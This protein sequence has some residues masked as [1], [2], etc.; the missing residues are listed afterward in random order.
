MHFCSKY[1]CILKQMLTCLKCFSNWAAVSSMERDSCLYLFKIFSIEMVEFDEH[2]LFPCVIYR[3]YDKN[4]WN[5]DESF[6][7]YV[8]FIY[9]YLF[10]YTSKCFP[11]LQRIKELKRQRLWKDNWWRMTAAAFII[12]NIFVVV[13]QA[14][15]HNNA[16]SNAQST[17]IFFMTVINL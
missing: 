9:T 8:T 1:V 12:K 4:D 7:F 17:S 2:I 10:S 3:W 6:M 15:E 13:H 16:F 14:A 5:F 11:M